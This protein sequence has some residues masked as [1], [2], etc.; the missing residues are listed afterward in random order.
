MPTLVLWK[1]DEG[2]GLLVMKRAKPFIATPRLFERDV[3]GD[4]LDDI[5]ALLDFVYNAHQRSRLLRYTSSE[6]QGAA[7]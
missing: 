5:E 1:Y 2:G 3:L 4:Y 6:R 7:S